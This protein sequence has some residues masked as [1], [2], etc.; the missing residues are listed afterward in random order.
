MNASVYSITIQALRVKLNETLL[1]IEK[2]NS[3][4]CS[5]PAANQLMNLTAFS[6]GTSLRTRDLK[7]SSNH[8]L[9]HP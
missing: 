7:F 6:L 8:P 5:G 2:E 4:P 9:P 1:Q 3:E